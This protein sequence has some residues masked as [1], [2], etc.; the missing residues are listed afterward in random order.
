[1]FPELDL[2]IK[3]RPGTAIYFEYTNREG[4]LDPR[5]LHGGSPV[6]RGE[7]WIATK[8]IRQGPYRS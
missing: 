7:K 1:V 5:C 3:P 6:V 2:A 4:L 8:W